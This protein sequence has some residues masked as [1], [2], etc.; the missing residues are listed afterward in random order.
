MIHTHTHTKFCHKRDSEVLKSQ[1]CS[2][3]ALKND[4]LEL[5]ENSH[6]YGYGRFHE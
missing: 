1:E 3:G 4:F 5:L 6:E 2:R